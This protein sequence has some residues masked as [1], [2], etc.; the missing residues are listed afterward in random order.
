M[1][2]KIRSD[3]IIELGTSTKMDMHVYIKNDNPREEKTVASKDIPLSFS[4]LV[5]FSFSSS[6]RKYVA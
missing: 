1:G 3:M 5:S 6:V 2:E 4:S